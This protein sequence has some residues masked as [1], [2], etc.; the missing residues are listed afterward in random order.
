MVKAE[1][2]AL[3]DLN[4]RDYGGT[5]DTMLAVHGL[6]GSVANWDA[7][8][9]LLAKN[10]RVLALDLPGFGLSPPQ[11]D[12]RLETHSAAVVRFIEV[13]GTSVHLMGNSM[14]GL[15][16]EF[17]AAARPDLVETLILLS[18]ATPLRWPD[19]H[20][21][22]LTSLRLGIEAIPLVGAQLLKAVGNRLTPDEIVDLSLRMITYDPTR[23]P[24]DVV[25]SLVDTATE[26][27]NFEWAATAINQSASSIAWHY[28]RPRDFVAM[29]R[30]ISAPTLLVQGAAD[31]IVSP[32]GVKWLASLR[33]DWAYVEMADTGHTPQLDAPVRLT[34][35]VEEWLLQ[36]NQALG[37]DNGV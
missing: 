14:G 10:R 36:V 6:G 11:S 8:G 3:S 19:P 34:K 25:D 28:R 2:R 30:D 15:V 16:S 5:G 26:R 22:F 20:F 18:P 32:S 33:S 1:S 37:V 13:L 24:L 7:V 9:P 29:I 4:W 17:V 31:H 35:I 27:S 21:N 12:Y 23:V